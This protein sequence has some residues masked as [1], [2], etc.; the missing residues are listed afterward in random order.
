MNKRKTS[1]V[2]PY[3]QYV[4]KCCWNCHHLWDDGETFGC[5][6]HTTLWDEKYEE[7]YLGGK[8]SYI[9]YLNDTCPDWVSVYLQRQQQQ[10]TLI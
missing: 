2:S 6:L 5:D 7:D 9:E 3:G 4:G 1:Y 10:A 8:D